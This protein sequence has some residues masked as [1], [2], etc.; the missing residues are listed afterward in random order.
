[1]V[2]RIS[3]TGTTSGRSDW[4][5][6]VFAKTNCKEAK[7]NSGVDISMTVGG[8][9]STSAPAA[10]PT[11]HARP[12]PT[13]GRRSTAVPTSQ[14]IPNT[15]QAHPH[16]V[17]HAVPVAEPPSL[18][19][20]AIDVLGTLGVFAW[21]VPGAVL[22]MPGLLIVVIIAAQMFGA[23]AWMPIVRRKLR[24]TGEEERQRIGPKSSRLGT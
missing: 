4:T 12:A 16:V 18:D 21:A 1:V 7:K 5:A 14:P 15:F 11:A 23:A 13:Q 20:P 22:T 24:G 19:N 3:V 2:L 9:V 6:S 10:K 17:Q 8:A